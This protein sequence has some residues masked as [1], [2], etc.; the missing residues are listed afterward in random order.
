MA[1]KVV[2]ALSWMVYFLRVNGEEAV[3]PEIVSLFLGAFKFYEKIS[4]FQYLPN[5]DGSIQA[6]SLAK[7]EA[8]ESLAPFNHAVHPIHIH[9]QCKNVAI[10]CGK[11]VNFCRAK[12]FKRSLRRYCNEECGVCAPVK[13]RDQLSR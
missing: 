7:L 2:V 13:C 9:R 1:I 5:L 8:Y 11:L 10:N 4:L 12:K 3:D 6:H